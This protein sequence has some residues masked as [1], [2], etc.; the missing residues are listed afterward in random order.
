VSERHREIEPLYGALHEEAVEVA[1]DRPK[2][3]RARLVIAVAIAA[4]ALACALW[5]A[6]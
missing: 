6:R 2:R 3:S 1:C 5:L 4:A